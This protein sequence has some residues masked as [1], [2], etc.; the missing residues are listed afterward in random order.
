MLAGTE[1]LKRLDQDVYHLRVFPCDVASEIGSVKRCKGTTNF[2]T[3]YNH[4]C[5]FLVY[6]LHMPGKILLVSK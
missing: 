1:T 3:A 4:G 6:R 5:I 2:W